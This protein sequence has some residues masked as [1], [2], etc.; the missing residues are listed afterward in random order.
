M[1]MDVNFTSSSGAQMPL[2]S[3]VESNTDCI[4]FSNGIQICYGY[5]GYSLRRMNKNRKALSIDYSKPFCEFPV[6]SVFRQLRTDSD[7]DTF[8][9][10]YRID[11]VTTNNTRCTYYLVNMNGIIENGSYW[12]GYFAIG[13]WK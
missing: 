11:M 7:S 12:V 9:E 2:V 8:N 5:C 6:C 4:R 3:I 10:N 1:P 13:R